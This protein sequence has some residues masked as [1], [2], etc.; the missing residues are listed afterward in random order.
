[1]T[2]PISAGLGAAVISGGAS[3]FGANKAADAQKDAAQQASDT[4]RQMFDV[5]Q[6]NLR[7]YMDAGA[8]ATTTL[9]NRLPEFTSPIALDQA[10]LEKTPGYQFTRN[11]GL[12]SVQNAA[13]ARGLGASGAALKG[14]AQFATGL[15]D[16]TYQ[17][18]FQNAITNQTNAYSRLLSLAGLGENAA[19]G[20]G[21]AAITTGQNIGNNITGAGNAE[22][23]SYLA[24][25]KGVGNAANSIPNYLLT[26]QLLQN[27]QQNSSNKGLYA[28]QSQQSLD[29][30]S[31][32]NWNG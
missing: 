25:A 5:T 32:I 27:Q 8:G 19:A 2:D 21:N 28:N 13:G 11:Q 1:M 22:G 20:V 12:K 23:A 16:S 18:Q 15:S 4:Q 14:A 7:P 26:N 29:F 10:W 31:G 17:N 3:I 6:E 30:G 24:A 9:T